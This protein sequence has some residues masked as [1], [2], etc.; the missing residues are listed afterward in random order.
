MSGQE[1]TPGRPWAKST[2]GRQVLTLAEVLRDKGRPKN[3]RR[4]KGTERRAKGMLICC[5][6][7]RHRSQLIE[8]KPTNCSRRAQKNKGW[9]DRLG[10]KTASAQA[11]DPVLVPRTHMVAYHHP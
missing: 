7:G 5:V 9:R 10:V 11:E 6:L 4:A 8:Y 2:T 1:E 3:Y